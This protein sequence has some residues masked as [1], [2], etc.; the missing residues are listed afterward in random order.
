MSA[1]GRVAAGERTRPPRYLHS[2]RGSRY[3]ARRG[4][5]PV[6]ER[7]G[8]LLQVVLFILAAALAAFTI[9]QGIAPHDE[10]LMLQAGARIASGQWPYRDFWS[11]Y[12]PGQPLVLAVLQEIFGASLLAW[13]VVAVAVDAGVA[14]LAYRLAQRRA[15][16]VYALGA[17]LAVASV[18]AFPTLPG[19]NPPALLLSFAALMAARR[20]PGLA[21]AIAGLAVL[22]RFELGLAA[23]AGV[24]LTAPRGR[25]ARAL[26]SA[27]AVAVVSLAPFALVAPHAMWHDTIGFYAHPGPPAPALPDRL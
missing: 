6:G 25:R 26:G 7:P 21:G 10:G 16:E 23:I 19:P 12:P 13:R 14:L 17:W 8:V 2:A 5:T 18:M 27:V 11:N 1:A 22:F 4:Q 3:E 20:R 24:L 9:V 15:P